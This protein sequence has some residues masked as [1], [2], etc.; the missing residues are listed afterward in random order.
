MNKHK[1]HSFLRKLTH[2]WLFQV[3][4]AVLLALLLFSPM[5]ISR[6]P[7]REE[8]SS[9]NTASDWEE[10]S[11]VFMNYFFRDCYDE[12][13]AVYAERLAESE[14]INEETPLD[15]QW[16]SETETWADYF[17]LYARS[18]S[19]NTYRIAREAYEQNYTVD[20]TPV[21][22]QLEHI[23]SGASANGFDSA[24]AYLQS[25]YGP[26]ANEETY[27]SYLALRHL[28]ESYS[29]CIYASESG[30]EEEKQAQWD[31]WFAALP[32]NVT[33][34]EDMLSQLYMTP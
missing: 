17:Y 8:G 22:E 16:C 2:H 14:I 20:M 11:P 25:F 4:S 29:E 26:L 33:V 5:I 27:K 31:S 18:D 6:L 19:I 9:L 3:G 7:S 30:S 10:V 24:D 34:R 21:H 13:K 32:E 23:R 15:L 1:K 12:F 28:A